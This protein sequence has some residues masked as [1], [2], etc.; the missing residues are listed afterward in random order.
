MPDQLNGYDCGVFCLEYALRAM[1]AAPEALQAALQG[2]NA[3]FWPTQ[4]RGLWVWTRL[5]E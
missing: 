2:L 3:A 5:S 1:S 4:V